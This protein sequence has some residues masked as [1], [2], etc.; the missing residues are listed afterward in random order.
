[1]KRMKT[2]PAELE[3]YP[4]AERT[5]RPHKRTVLILAAS[6]REAYAEAQKVCR[7]ESA[8]SD[9]TVC[10]LR[11]VGTAVDAGQFVSEKLQ[12]NGIACS[13][14]YDLCDGEVL[15]CLSWNPA[16]VH[17]RCDEIL[18]TL[19]YRKVQEVVTEKNGTGPYS[20]EHLYKIS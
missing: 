6:R 9:L 10:P 14:A 20:S 18:K 5:R 4:H 1:M 13:A 8:F 2:Y 19:G 11:N 17:G 7:S 3:T 15:V 12:M 16:C